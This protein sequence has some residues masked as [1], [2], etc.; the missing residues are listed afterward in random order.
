[1]LSSSCPY[2]QEYSARQI[3]SMCPQYREISKYEY[4]EQNTV[5][6][7]RKIKINSRGKKEHSA[8]EQCL[9]PLCLKTQKLKYAKL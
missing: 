9:I 5:T 6:Y 4:K 3:V 2:I 8:F 7:G 1:M